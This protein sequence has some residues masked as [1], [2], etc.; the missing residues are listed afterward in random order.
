MTRASADTFV[1]ITDAVPDL[2]SATMTEAT[3]MAARS[4]IPRGTGWLLPTF[5]LLA[6]TAGCVNEPVRP[7]DPDTSAVTTSPLI[8]TT[9]PAASEPV[10]PRDTDGPTV[11]PWPTYPWSELPREPRE[12]DIAPRQSRS[13]G[14]RRPTV[15]PEAPSPS[16]G[17]VEIDHGARS[18]TTGTD[19]GL[20]ES[21]TGTLR[22]HASGSPIDCV[23][24]RQVV[25]AHQDS[26]PAGAQP[27]APGS[28]GV[29]IGEW[30]CVVP[31]PS[32]TM[33]ALDTPAAD[34]V[35]VETRR[36][37]IGGAAPTIQQDRVDPGPGP[38]VRDA[39]GAGAAG[40]DRFAAG[41]TARPAP[42][43]AAHRESIEAAPSQ[44]SSLDA[45]LCTHADGVR[46]LLATRIA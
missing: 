16:P 40:A 45:G 8:E 4:S 7:G 37:G 36:L 27:G 15:V 13:P 35:A 34:R 10:D 25:A 11:E 42:G 22:V 6:I 31:T 20:V 18:D 17:G 41:P 3:F 26:L 24:A 9:D 23:R 46:V 12:S 1:S 44:T 43:D 14:D 21:R 32:E 30:Y 33:A 39:A 29:R 38:T 2:D 5:V 19:C 28:E